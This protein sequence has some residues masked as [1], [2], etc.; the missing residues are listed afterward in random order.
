MFVREAISPRDIGRILVR[1]GPTVPLGPII[2]V[3]AEDPKARREAVVDQ[4]SVEFGA[5][6]AA[7]QGLAMFLA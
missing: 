2:A 6:P 1:T 5:R 7:R 4:P 3:Q